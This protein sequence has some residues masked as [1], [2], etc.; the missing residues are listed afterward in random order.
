MSENKS[1]RDMAQLSSE[2][3]Q[4]LIDSGGE[5]DESLE[6]DLAILEDRLPEKVDGYKS[7]IDYMKHQAEY[8]KAQGNERLAVA[9]SLTNYADK[10]KE[11]MKGAMLRMNVAE[12]RGRDFKFLL[13]NAKGR[14]VIENEELIPGKFKKVVQVLEIDKELIYEELKAGKQVSG[15]RLEPS[16]YAQ[17]YPLTSK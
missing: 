10:L 12:L 8:W 11:S 3:T 7:I 9:K 5:I 2:I 14:I 6:K 4:R 13:K 16:Q 15:A 17:A 1:L